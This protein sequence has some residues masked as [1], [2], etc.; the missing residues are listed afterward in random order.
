M[1]WE[2]WLEK[3]GRGENSRHN[4]VAQFGTKE[5]QPGYMSLEDWLKVNGDRPESRAT[6]NARFGDGTPS[7]FKPRAAPARDPN[8]TTSPASFE[9]ELARGDF[10]G[11]EGTY[12]QS[13]V[14]R[15][16]KM[17]ANNQSGNS[18]EGFA[19]LPP[20]MADAIMKDIATGKIRKTRGGSTRSAIMG[21]YGVA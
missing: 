17:I 11:M 5:Q 1:P 2:E 13:E 3:W 16:R 14:A 19:V 15:R 9:E 7:P 6:W 21:S 10:A 4:W 12:I 8:A 20:D 18:P